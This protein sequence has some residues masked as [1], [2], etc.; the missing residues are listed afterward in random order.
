LIA[1]RILDAEA[2]KKGLTADRLLEQEVDAKIA[3]LDRCGIEGGVCGAERAESYI[4]GN[5]TST[6]A[7]ADTG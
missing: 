2:K 5:E 4:R 1:Q 7:N 3:E 6:G